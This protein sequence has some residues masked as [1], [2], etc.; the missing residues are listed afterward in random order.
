MMIGNGRDARA[1][2]AALS[3]IALA[4]AEGQDFLIFADSLAARRADL[5]TLA[6]SLKL[7][8]RLS[9]IEELEGRRDLMLHGDILMLPEAG[10]EQRSVVLEA[11]ACGMLLVAAHDKES[12]VLQEGRTAA[13]VANN[14]AQ[15]WAACL[16]DL[17]RNPAKSVALAASAHLFVQV[18]RRA[19]DH[20]RGVISAYE[21][22][23]TG[24]SIP[25]GG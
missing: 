7:L 20:V 17:I 1:W 25:F 19:S 11:M 24:E 14:T 23:A 9:L 21:Y 22:L 16:T 10:G 15:S 5:W 13:L 6:R 2:A 12:S 18:H 3:G 8:D 4:A